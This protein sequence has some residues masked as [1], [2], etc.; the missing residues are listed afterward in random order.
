MN[1]N[2]PNNFNNN[3]VGNPNAAGA[4]LMG[5]QSQMGPEPNVMQGLENTQTSMNPVQGVEAPQ[6][7]P[8]IMQ[9]MAGPEQPQPA[10]MPGQDNSGINSFTMQV[11]QPQAPAMP[12]PAMPDPAMPAAVPEMPAAP[13]MGMPT[14]TDSIVNTNPIDG[15]IPNVMAN[16]GMQP[17]A[18]VDPTMPPVDSAPMNNVDMT[19][20]TDPNMAMGQA[21]VMPNPVMPE[22]AMPAAPEMP[23]PEPM[24]QPEQPQM[25]PDPNMGVPPVMPAAPMPA[26]PEMPAAPEMN[27][28][29][30]PEAANV[31]MEQPQMMGSDGEEDDLPQKKFPLSTRE[32]VLVSIALVGIV[33][34]IIVYWP[35]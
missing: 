8:G 29:G 12:N 24:M 1:N 16:V 15:A 17:E 30:S 11:E 3:P 26:V 18:P 25:M 32:I 9:G 23:A 4:Q 21:P 14:A 20:P 7:N 19:M 31:G 35:K 34:V 33:A 27:T 13:E 6:P 5:G 2:M 28:I 22:P 10:V